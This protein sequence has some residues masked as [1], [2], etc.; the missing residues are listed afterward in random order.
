VLEFEDDDPNE[1]EFPTASDAL[2]ELPED[3]SPESLLAAA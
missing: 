2:P 3:E 1:L